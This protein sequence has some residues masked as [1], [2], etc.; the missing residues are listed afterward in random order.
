MARTYDL[1]VELL[2]VAPR[3]WRRVRVPADV[4]LADLH[5]VI[6]VVMQWSDRHLH[7]F[8]VGDREYGPPPGEELE[9][10]QWAGHDGDITV[11]QAWAQANGAIEY[12]YD[13]GNE[14]RAR[15]TE[16]ADAS[17][18]GLAVIK[19]LVGEGAAPSDSG[20]EAMPF[21]L[22][23]INVRLRTDTAEPSRERRAPPQFADAAEQLLADVTLLTLFLG[24]W[25]ERNGLRMAWK[26]VRFEILDVMTEAGLIA[27][28]RARKSL[29]LTDEGVR[30][31]EGLRERVSAALSGSASD[32]LPP[33]RPSP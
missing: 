16:A 26:T 13:F 28:T 32:S 27:T 14:W 33:W 9:D 18:P 21:D 12:V 6:Q 23:A 19:C 5:H 31:A 24:S 15:I 7:V 17:R 25:E 22:A 29:V 1:D 30:R 8:E 4:S 20:G 11:A 10:P 3:V 2:G